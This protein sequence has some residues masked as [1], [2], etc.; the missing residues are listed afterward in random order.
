VKVI[1]A[2]SRELNDYEFIKSKIKET[3]F[4]ITEIVSGG[5]RG[6]DSLGER[7]AKENNIPVKVFPADWTKFGKAAGPIRNKEMADYGDSLIAFPVDGG[8]GTSNMIDTMRK[9][10]KPVEVWKK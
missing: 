3:K 1:I 2:G 10:H 7:Y 6:V 8:R 9:L 4:E 5:A